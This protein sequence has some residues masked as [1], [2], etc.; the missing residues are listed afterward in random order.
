M[1]DLTQTLLIIVIVILTVLLCFIGYQV[2]MVLR[3]A[4]RSLER[5]NGLVDQAEDLMMKLSHPAEGI[6][7][8]LSGVKQ[9]VQVFETISSLFK[10]RAKPT[11]YENDL[12]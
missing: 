9:G 6:N 4:R 8:L 3:E 1:L 5:A 12:P 2:I 11:D 10:S 7:N